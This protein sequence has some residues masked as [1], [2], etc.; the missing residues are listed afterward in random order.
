MTLKTSLSCEINDLIYEVVSYSKKTYD[1]V[2]TAFLSA[3]LYPESRKTFIMFNSQ[4]N[5][6]LTDYVLKQNPE[7]IWLDKA[8]VSIFTTNNIN[9]IYITE[10]I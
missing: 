6:V 4:K 9:S 10:A 5:S 8:L 1:E 7:L 2:E 3:Y